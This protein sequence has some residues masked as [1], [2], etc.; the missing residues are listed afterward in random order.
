MRA[1]NDYAPAVILFQY[2]SVDDCE[3]A[4]DIRFQQRLDAPLSVDTVD[5]MTRKL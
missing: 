3:I 1:R 4:I 2:P 5:W